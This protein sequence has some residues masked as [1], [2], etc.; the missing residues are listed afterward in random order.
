MGANTVFEM[1]VSEKEVWEVGWEVCQGYDASLS[2]ALCLFARIHQVGVGLV[3]VWQMP[4]SSRIGGGCRQ[5][6]GCAS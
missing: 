3:D 6:A 4:P 5:P 1:V 2:A